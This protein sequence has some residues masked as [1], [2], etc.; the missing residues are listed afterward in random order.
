MQKKNEGHV[1]VGFCCFKNKRFFR[2]ISM[3]CGVIINSIS[4][5]GGCHVVHYDNYL[6]EQIQ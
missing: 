4:V 1:Y 3:C 6:L 2:Y 5:E